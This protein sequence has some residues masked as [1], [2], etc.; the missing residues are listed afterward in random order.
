MK[1]AWVG[2]GV[3]ARLLV[4]RRLGPEGAAAVAAAGSREQA[5]M[6]LART[7]YA[8][9][10]DTGWDAGGVERVLAEVTLLRLRLLTGWLPAGAP[11]LMRSLAAWFEIANIDDRL[12]YLGGASVPHP[13]RLG[14]LATAWPQ[15]SAAQ[16]PGE[17]RAVLA[18]SAWGD[19]GTEDGAQIALALRVAWARRVCDDVPEARPWAAGALALLLASLLPHLELPP[20]AHGDAA[21]VVGRG[22]ERARTVA[23]LRAVLPAWGRRALDGADEEGLWRAEGRWWRELERA[24]AA[25]LAAPRADRGAVVGA[26]VLLAA[27]ARRTAAAHEAAARGALREY[28]ETFGAA[29]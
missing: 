24:G 29:A 16:T 3:R 11:A 20:H 10:A 14:S 19:P 23:D 18:S 7:S 21:R 1:A 22:W 28:E 5:A 12:A 2:A 6:L 25:L 17:L 26:V 9:E 13:F 15:L 8:R 4:A 27:D